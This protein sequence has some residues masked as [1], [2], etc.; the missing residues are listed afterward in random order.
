MTRSACVDHGNGA[1]SK[2]ADLGCGAGAIV[3]RFL[4]SRV[5]IWLICQ[6][7]SGDFSNLGGV[8]Y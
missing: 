2:E 7:V 3:I 1:D 6:G 8:S 5:H 4:D